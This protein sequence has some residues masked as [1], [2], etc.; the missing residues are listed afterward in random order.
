MPAIAMSSTAPRVSLTIVVDHS[1]KTHTIVG[2]RVPASRPWRPR[3]RAM[4]VLPMP[5]SSVLSAELG[6]ANL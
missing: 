3:T 2:R 4:Q 6:R 5:S 1:E